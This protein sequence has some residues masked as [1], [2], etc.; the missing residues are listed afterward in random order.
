MRLSGQVRPLDMSAARTRSL[1]SRHASSGRPTTLNAGRPLETCTSTETG[2]PSA[3]SNVAD[4]TMAS[5]ANP[6]SGGRP[7]DGQDS[8]KRS[9][10][11][12]GGSRGGNVAG[13]CVGVAGRPP[14]L[15]RLA[16]VLTGCPASTALRAMGSRVVV[17][18]RSG[19]QDALAVAAEP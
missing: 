4:G 10:A 14:R 1:D 8:P 2:R 7:T 18:P 12:G 11:D 9:M 6:L 3:P 17:S 19:G 13:G 16:P 5:T 15:S